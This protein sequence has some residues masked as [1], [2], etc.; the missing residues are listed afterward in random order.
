MT[1]NPETFV[2]PPLSP[3]PR[4]ILTQMQEGVP[5]T[6]AALSETATA[7]HEDPGKATTHMVRYALR[8]LVDSG[9]VHRYVGPRGVFS[10]TAPPLY[11]L[12]ETGLHT[13]SSPPSPRPRKSRSG[14]TRQVI[15]DTIRK[16]G[17]LERF[18][19]SDRSGIN[20]TTAFHH[21]KDLVASGLVTRTTVKRVAYYSIPDSEA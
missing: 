11:R 10:R 5:Y 19:L 4:F 18:A 20:V 17:P 7:T 1:E 9:L 8:V 16:F 6:T 13:K 21:T 12:T 14:F 15:L 3:L 2:P